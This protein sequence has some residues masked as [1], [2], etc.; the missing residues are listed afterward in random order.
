MRE[1]ERMQVEMRFLALDDLLPHGHRARFVWEY[2]EELDLSSLYGKIKAVEGKEGRPTIDPKILMG[3]WLYATLE[4]VGSARE[5][6]RR[7]ETD[8]A[9]QW[10]CGGVGVNHHT[11]SDFRC[12]HVELLD[13]LLTESVA[14]LMYC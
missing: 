5:I 8:S 2:V 1:A 4:G 3:L 14:S 11:L 12:G 9:Y 10:I 7:T 13:E 6:A